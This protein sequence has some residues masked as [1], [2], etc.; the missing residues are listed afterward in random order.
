MENI[1]NL[2]PLLIEKNNHYSLIIRKS[3]LLSLCSLMFYCGFFAFWY[4]IVPRLLL[5]SNKIK[6]FPELLKAV[7]SISVDNFFDVM[8]FFAVFVPLVFSLPR[9]VIDLLVLFRGKVFCF[10][11]LDKSISINS[12]KISE[13]D[14]VESLLLKRYVHQKTPDSYK[15]SIVLYNGNKITIEESSNFELMCNAADAIANILNVDVVKSN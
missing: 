9:I 10:N 15:L 8:I 11:S 4:S 5:S 12:E 7:Q 1:F 13:F 14:Q 3:K 2:K 6:S